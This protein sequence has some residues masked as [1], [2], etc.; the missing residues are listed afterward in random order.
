MMQ[1]VHVPKYD[2]QAFYNILCHVCAQEAV[3]V[4]WVLNE[5]NTLATR[6]ARHRAMK[7][8][9]EVERA[10]QVQIAHFFG[11]TQASVSRMLEQ[12]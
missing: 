7:A 3:D 4:D 8:I 6:T 1:R 10:S 11:L 2:T 5:C 12:A 9:R